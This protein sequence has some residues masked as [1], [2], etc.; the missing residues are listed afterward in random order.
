MCSLDHQS[1]CRG[2]CV[3]CFIS[4]FCNGILYAYVCIQLLLEWLFLEP[5]LNFPVFSSTS[6]N[7]RVHMKES[8]IFPIFNNKK[9]IT[10]IIICLLSKIEMVREHCQSLSRH[11]LHYLMLPAESFLLSFWYWYVRAS[12]IYRNSVGLEA[13]RALDIST[14]HRI[15]T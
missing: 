1:I 6:K 8:V 2:V 7:D 13:W 3:Q 11:W 12:A 4:V 14:F 5:F 9:E 10:D 15:L